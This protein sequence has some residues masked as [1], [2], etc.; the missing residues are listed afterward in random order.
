MILYK[1]ADIHVGANV[2]LRKNICTIISSGLVN[3]ALGTVLSIASRHITVKFD[4]NK[5]LYHQL[6]LKRWQYCVLKCENK[7]L[8][9]QMPTSQI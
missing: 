9:Y 2:M 3:E 8:V 6:K 1:K 5:L 7:P 4:H